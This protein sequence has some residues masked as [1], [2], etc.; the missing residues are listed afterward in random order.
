MLVRLLAHQLRVLGPP[1]GFVGGDEPERPLLTDDV[2][3]LVDLALAQRRVGA[4]RHHGDLAVAVLVRELVEQVEAL[5]PL[6]ALAW[7]E[8]KPRRARSGAAR[9]IVE[10]PMISGGLPKLAF[11]LAP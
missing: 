3:C 4:Q 10:S 9:T 2:Q 5:G 6:P 7:F 11:F 8:M 1:T